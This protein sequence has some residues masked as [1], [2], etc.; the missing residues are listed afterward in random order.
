MIRSPS[1]REARTASDA[2]PPSS[3][4]HAP[5]IDHAWPDCFKR[6]Q[7][8]QVVD[9][10]TIG[11][12]VLA[13]QQ[14]EA[15]SEA[16]TAMRESLVQGI[17]MASEI[18]IPIQAQHRS[19]VEAARQALANGELRDPPADRCRSAGVQLALDWVAAC[20]KELGT[21]DLGHSRAAYIITKPVP[22]PERLTESATF[23]VPMELVANDVGAANRGVKLPGRLLATTKAAVNEPHRP[24]LALRT[25]DFGQFTCE[26]AAVS[27][28]EVQAHK[29]VQDAMDMFQSALYDAH[30]ASESLGEAI[31]RFNRNMPA[32]EQLNL[33]E[34]EGHS[35]SHRLAR[36]ADQLRSLAGVVKFDYQML[37]GDSGDGALLDQRLGIDPDAQACLSFARRKA[38]EMEPSLQGQLSD[39]KLPPGNYRPAV[40]R[41]CIVQMIMEAA[42]RGEDGVAK[43]NGARGGRSW[44]FLTPIDTAR[45]L[46]HPMER[47]AVDAFMQLASEATRAESSSPARK[48]SREEWQVSMETAIPRLSLCLTHRASGD[49]SASPGASVSGGPISAPAQRPH[50][51]D[52]HAPHSRH[53]PLP[54][55]APLPRS[56]AVIRSP[57]DAIP[58]WPAWG[59]QP[60][61][62]Q[63]A[64]CLNQLNPRVKLDA[65][66]PS[67]D[68]FAKPVPVSD[69]L[70]ECSAVTL[71]LSLVGNDVQA[72]TS[73]TLL[74]T[75]GDGHAPNRPRLELRTNDQGQLMVEAAPVLPQ[76]TSAHRRVQELQGILQ[77]ALHA[78][79]ADGKSLSLAVDCYNE[80]VQPEERLRLVASGT[81]SAHQGLAV[82]LEQPRRET[83]LLRFNYGWLA[84]DSRESRA[85]DQR[86]EKNPDTWGHLKVARK[87]AREAEFEL[88]AQMIKN[89]KFSGSSYRPAVVRGCIVQIVMESIA[90]RED[91]IAKEEEVQVT[92]SWQFNT[93]IARLRELLHSVEQAVVDTF[94]GS[95]KRPARSAASA[96]EPPP[97]ESPG[98]TI[99]TDIPRACLRITDLKVGD[100]GVGPRSL[101]MLEA[102]EGS[103]GA[104]SPTDAI[105]HGQ[106]PAKRARNESPRRDH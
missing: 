25:N 52:P 104:R 103:A 73:A 35:G 4:P 79:Q 66:G 21:R 74:A 63:E 24:W 37:A 29:H 75:T 80:K 94:I 47:T 59:S 90:D 3:E 36:Q 84:G 22:V 10:A 1:V 26:F 62:R 71:P 30:E 14:L 50:Q 87:Q 96:P 92:R 97:N 53:L 40:V 49:P 51:A 15:G 88:R 70:V 44:Q 33:V 82:E 65:G 7:P 85:L 2:T 20:W 64:P 78:A 106:P 55:F 32:D 93:P 72:T 12:C 42:A 89:Q 68:T 100:T 67:L 77:D 6:L 13:L 19:A 86:V 8:H 23:T 28:R 38:A 69:M 102:L 60:A 101:A 76:D 83:T 91:E 17:A 31:A 34:S 46:L 48:P 45:M 18:R 11:E 56:G 5:P 16:H 54:P 105:L 58:A 57:S 39:G 95:I 61:R 9:G 41:G 98:T 81:L 43:D 27:P 99:G